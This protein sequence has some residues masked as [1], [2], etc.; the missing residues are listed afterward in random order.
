[1][2]ARL[3]VACSEAY[4]NVN[5]RQHWAPR[6]RLTR[7]WRV[8]GFMAA[9]S[10]ML[11]GLPQM[12]RA[13]I[14]ARISFARAHSGDV[15]NWYPTIKAVLDGVIGDAGL[16]PDDSDAHLIGPDMRRGPK[17]PQRVEL[18][19]TELEALA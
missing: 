11:D 16:L 2:S 7:A 12:K 4:I 3:I 17:G 9:R 5:Q 15:A 10:A 6:A 19:I 14:E 13:H 1:M 8:A 18:I